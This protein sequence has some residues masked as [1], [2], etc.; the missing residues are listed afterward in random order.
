VPNVSRLISAANGTRHQYPAMQRFESIPVRFLQRNG[1]AK[2]SLWHTRYTTLVISTPMFNG[3]T[4]NVIPVTSR[5]LNG[6]PSPESKETQPHVLSPENFRPLL[7]PSPDIR[8]V[9]RGSART[10]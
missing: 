7:Q 6:S 9:S 10:K 2:L 8:D 1:F 5:T 3:R 4:L